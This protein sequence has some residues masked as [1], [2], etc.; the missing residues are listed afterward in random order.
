MSKSFCVYCGADL[1]PDAVFCIM[2]GAAVPATSPTTEQEHAPDSTMPPVVDSAWS[3]APQ[4]PDPM[5][6]PV[7]AWT[8]EASF[9]APCEP[10]VEESDGATVVAEESSWSEQEEYDSLAAEPAA[11]IIEE[12]E[13]LPAIISLGILDAEGV[14]SSLEITL[15]DGDA[16]TIGRDGRVTDYVPE[17]P[18]AS[19]R[20]FSISAS[21]EGLNLIDLGSSNGTYV[22]GTR[23]VESTW[24]NDGDTIEYGRSKAT[25]RILQLPSVSESSGGTFYV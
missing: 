19:R 11:T 14:Q 16:Y 20:H 18:R 5:D 24:L 13:P 8:P 21:A 7:P 12:P 3:S 25:L 9:N 23:V 1:Q 10:V 17:D 6:S 15:A 4:A 22:N 2:C